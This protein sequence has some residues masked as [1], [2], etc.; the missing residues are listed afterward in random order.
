MNLRNLGLVVWMIAFSLG[1]AGCAITSEAPENYLSDIDF[2]GDKSVK[3]LVRPNPI[4]TSGS[5]LSSSDGK[6]LALVDV[7][8]QICDVDGQN[9]E[10]NC[11]ISPI[12]KAVNPKFARQAGDDDEANIVLS[13]L[14]GDSAPTQRALDSLY[15]YD[16]KTLFVAFRVAG[17]EADVEGEIR[18]EPRVKRCRLQ[19]DNSLECE[20][21]ETVSK[22]LFKQETREL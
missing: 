3:Y 13:M 17:G 5:K 7:K 2:V 20:R 4:S 11:T 8:A 22:A 10:T 21:D 1:G 9:E 6:D 16:E 19:S 12:L 15:W 14:G 18:S